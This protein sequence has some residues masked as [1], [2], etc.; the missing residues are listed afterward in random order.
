[1]KW[2]QR[3]TYQV[4]LHF[5]R[6]PGKITVIIDE[7]DA[8]MFDDFA[9]YYKSTK[10]NSISVIG[11]TATAY[12]GKDTGVEKRALDKLNYKVYPPS[13]DAGSL[14]PETHKR[15]PLGTVEAYK[16]FIKA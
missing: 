6:S 13:N 3:V 2:D 16:K 10:H 1:M 8:I 12:S 4:G 9:G 14:N 7:S 15:V 5:T 11:L